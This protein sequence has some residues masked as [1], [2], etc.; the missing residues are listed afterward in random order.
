MPTEILN[1]PQ[2]KET[3]VGDL[4]WTAINQQLIG[5]NRT[6]RGRYVDE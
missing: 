4:S 2:W 6:R 3:S 1:F 5:K